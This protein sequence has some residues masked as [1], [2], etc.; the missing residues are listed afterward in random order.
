MHMRMRTTTSS[1]P[2]PCR[3]HGLR[4]NLDNAPSV[5]LTHCK[6]VNVERGPVWRPGTVADA[7]RANM[8][9]S[10]AHCIHPHMQSLH[11]LRLQIKSQPPERWRPS[12]L[13]GAKPYDNPTRMD[14]DL[15]PTLDAQLFLADG[16]YRPGT[17]GASKPQATSARWNR[18]A[19]CR[20][21][22]QRWSSLS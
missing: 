6:P 1:L 9:R 7:S 4:P 10:R 22:Q 20:P 8:G 19:R 21:L 13:D 16:A 2:T 3:A 17:A 5:G 11:F 18:G 14:A 15:K 12:R